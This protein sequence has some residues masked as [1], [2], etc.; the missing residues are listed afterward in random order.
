MQTEYDLC[1]HSCDEELVVLIYGDFSVS[2]DHEKI[3]IALYYMF[4]AVIH[5]LHS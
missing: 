3:V 4:T 1:I 2:K 5:L